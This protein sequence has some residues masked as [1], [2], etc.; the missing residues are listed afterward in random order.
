M[1]WKIKF[2][3]LCSLICYFGKI[4][5]TFIYIIKGIEQIFFLDKS[6][7]YLWEKNIF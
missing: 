5:F 2:E 1:L 3:H 7:Y 6:N 4:L